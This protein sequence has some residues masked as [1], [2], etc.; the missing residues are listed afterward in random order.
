LKQEIVYVEPQSVVKELRIDVKLFGLFNNHFVTHLAIIGVIFVY[1]SSQ[2]Q[3]S[4][5][6]LCAAT[7]GASC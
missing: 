6:T 4:A 3:Q 2:T 1:S 7:G 5:A